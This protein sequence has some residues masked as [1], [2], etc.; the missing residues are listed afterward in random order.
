MFFLYIKPQYIDVI[1]TT[2]G[3]NA[4]SRLGLFSTCVGLMTITH[5]IQ[6]HEALHLLNAAHAL[7]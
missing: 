4:V 1:M 5:I 2:V 3:P 7:T 6:Y